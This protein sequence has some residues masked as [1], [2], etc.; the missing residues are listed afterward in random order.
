[1]NSLRTKL[2]E[3]GG[4]TNAALVKQLKGE[5]QDLKTALALS[6]KEREGSPRLICG[7]GKDQLAAIENQLL[8]ERKENVRLD[9]EIREISAQLVAARS[10]L[11]AQEPRERVENNRGLVGLQKQI[12]DLEQFKRECSAESAKLREELNKC[13][14]SVTYKALQDNVRTLTNDLVFAEDKSSYLQK[15]IDTHLAALENYKLQLETCKDELR[16]E[17]AKVLIPNA[18]PTPP[19]VSPVTGVTGATVNS[20]SSVPTIWVVFNKPNQETELGKLPRL[21]QGELPQATAFKVVR[22]AETIPFGSYKKRS[23]VL[24]ITNAPSPRTKQMID[25]SLLRSFTDRDDLS[26]NVVFRRPGVDVQPLSIPQLH[27][28]FPTTYFVELVFNPDDEK[29]HPEYVSGGV[30]NGTTL[31]SLIRRISL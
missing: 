12:Q 5:I 4:D 24:Y 2:K 18:S 23:V 22:S 16:K 25:F 31:G 17:K 20:T 1:M 28:D 9:N 3:L 7:E 19:T 6:Q 26:V 21:I 27:A 14:D 11:A 30:S 29:I 15:D 10:K 8:R 13:P